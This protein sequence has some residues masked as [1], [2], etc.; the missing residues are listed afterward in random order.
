[1]QKIIT[2]TGKELTVNWCG[3]STI[4]FTLR[5][6][7]SDWSMAELFQVF[8]NQEE[9]STLIHMF[10]SYETKYED[11]TVFRGVDL[12]PDGEIVVALNH[13]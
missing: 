7:T 3:V 6:G 4:D 8:T 1:M 9:T 5:F 12:K 10:D 13:K 11:Y 2:A